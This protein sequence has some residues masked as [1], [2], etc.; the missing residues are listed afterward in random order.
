M[1]RFDPEFDVRAFQEK[2]I[3][4]QNGN[5]VGVIMLIMKL[6]A[7]FISILI[8]T[9]SFVVTDAD[10]FKNLIN[11][12]LV[13]TSI[14]NI[15]INS[16]VIFLPFL[17]FAI[18]TSKGNDYSSFFTKPKTT[19]KDTA[20]YTFFALFLSYVAGFVNLIVSKL[21]QLLIGKEPYSPE[22]GTS[23]GN[24]A[25]AIIVEIVCTC[26]LTALIEEFAFRGVLLT[27]LRKFGDV[28]AIVISSLV[29]AVLHGNFV[30]I[31]YVFVFSMGLA[32]V[33]IKT[34]S[35]YPAILVHFINNSIV[36]L[37]SWAPD[38]TEIFSFILMAFSVVVSFAL[39]KE[40]KLTL[41]KTQNFALSNSK[42]IEFLITS[43]FLL[44]YVIYEIV[45][46]LEFLK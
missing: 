35:I 10:T 24:A 44:L 14:I 27:Y 37:Y 29:F 32:F 39:K 25:F 21:F 6:V 5:T 18:Y 7:L 4:R 22:L 30:Q 16:F 3:L 9:I 42:R 45:M 41:P 23:Y 17:F 13:F 19:N 28:P 20:K 36:T 12:D 26:I 40:K 11:D 46:S 15:I 31:P 2:T 1:Y 34:N 43:P 33:T 38:I 8:G